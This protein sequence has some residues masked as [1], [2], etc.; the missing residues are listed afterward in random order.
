MKDSVSEAA[1]VRG[2]MADGCAA[3]EPILLCPATTGE[4][5]AQNCNYWLA[6]YYCTAPGAH[7]PATDAGT[8]D[9][10]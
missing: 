4:Q 5:S 6:A 1:E 10:R 7:Q 9:Y 2:S 8:A 3:M